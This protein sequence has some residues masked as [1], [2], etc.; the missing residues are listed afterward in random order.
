MIIRKEFEFP[1]LDVDGI[2][3]VE[4]KYLELLHKKRSTGH[5]ED[6]EM[7]YYDYANN[8]LMTT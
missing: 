5:L 6:A 3:A 8:V 7:D 2:G 4:K 1:R